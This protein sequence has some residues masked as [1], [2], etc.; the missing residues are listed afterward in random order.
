MATM[1]SV[2]IMMVT[3]NLNIARAPFQVRAL[4][5]LPRSVAERSAKLAEF[6]ANLS[7]RPEAFPLD[8]CCALLAARMI[9]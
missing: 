2:V 4:R 5:S 7:K 3:E 9:D 1:L 8:R 6:S